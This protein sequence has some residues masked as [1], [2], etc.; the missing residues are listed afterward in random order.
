MFQIMAI[1]PEVQAVSA[2]ERTKW[3]WDVHP[4]QEGKHQLYLT[5]TALIDIDGQN[6]PRMIKTF[7]QSIEVSV[8][9]PQKISLFF[10]NNWQWLWAAIFVPLGGWLWQRKAVN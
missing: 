1:T 7:D 10:K 4:K 6:T 3:K 5:L 2:V 8:T 9:T